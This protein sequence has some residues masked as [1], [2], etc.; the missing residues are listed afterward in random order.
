MKWHDFFYFSKGERSG[1]IILLCIIVIAGTILFL[2]KTS[3]PAS[4]H[5]ESQ[6]INQPSADRNTTG[7]VTPGDSVSL[8]KEIKN[9]SQTP[10]AKTVTSTSGTT[11]SSS[12][13]SSKESSAAKN[14]RESIPER[15]NRLTSYSQP[16]YTRV[17]KLAEGSI[18]ELNTADTTLL[19]K[20]PGIGSA[21][22]NRIV[23]YR[24]VLRGFHSVTQLSEVYG[25]DEE[26]YV[27]LFPW[28]TADPSFIHKIEIN[29]IPQDSLQRHPYISY[30]Q[31]RV[32]MQLRRQKGKL[33]GW[34]NL[35]LLN[36]FTEN[37]KTRLQPY[38]SF[39]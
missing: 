25:I 17:E 28:F 2:N 30:A 34:E 5:T 22:A 36:E 29:K 23:N 38:L 10:A 15:V 1:L 12:G 24:T 27:A 14:A 31:A 35:Q 33:A 9:T 8:G 32:I 18:V 16:T 20:V 4:Q 11:T 19:K 21:F 26:R 3:G 6:P 7:T 39:E 37:D 13:L